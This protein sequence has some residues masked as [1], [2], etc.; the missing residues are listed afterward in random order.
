MLRSRIVFLVVLLSVFSCSSPP[1]S[2]AEY[3]TNK[4]PTGK[5]TVID[6]SDELR[7]APESGLLA[8]G[9]S[10]TR[11]SPV[12]DKIIDYMGRNGRVE[13]EV[14]VSHVYRTKAYR[15]EGLV[16]SR[17]LKKYFVSQGIEPSRIRH[18]T[19]LDRR[20]KYPYNSPFRKVLVVLTNIKPQP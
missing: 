3:L 15:Q 10:L 7:F 19:F 12:L 20:S 14:K 4:L 16:K 13:A 8:V 18:S 11:A 1:I 5:V 17:N 6:I 2:G 9:D